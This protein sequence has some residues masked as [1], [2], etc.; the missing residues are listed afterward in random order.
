VNDSNRGL[1]SAQRRVLWIVLVAALI[2]FLAWLIPK[3]LVKDP[4]QVLEEQ[5]RVQKGALIL[6]LPPRPA[7]YP[8][9]VLLPR[10]QNAPVVFVESDDTALKRG[11]KYKLGSS[12]KSEGQAT[13][14][15]ESDVLDEV[16]EG[17]EH[18][19]LEIEI[20]RGQV[21]E[22]LVSDL[23]ARLKSSTIAADSNADVVVRSFEGPIRYRLARRSEY[24]LEL[25]KSF[26]DRLKS[27]DFADELVEV[28]VGAGS[29][30]ESEVTIQVSEPVVFAYVVSPASELSGVQSIDD[31]QLVPRSQMRSDTQA[32][33]VGLL[34]IG[35]SKLPD[36]TRSLRETGPGAEAA[37]RQVIRTAD[38]IRKIEGVHLYMKLP[39]PAA[40]LRP[41]RPGS[42]GSDLRAISAAAQRGGGDVAFLKQAL[43]SD[44][45]TSRLLAA[46][47]LGKLS[48]RAAPAAGSL[49]THLVDP[50]PAVRIAAAGA[51]LRVTPT[52]QVTSAELELASEHP[53]PAVRAK[54]AKTL[55]TQVPKAEATLLLER[56]ANDPDPTV[57]RAAEQ[58][59]RRRNI[60]IP[61]RAS[62]LERVAP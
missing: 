52:A 32:A 34:K 39:P 24:S 16:A 19:E 35:A 10:L 58:S 20:P 40:S 36:A 18:L 1:S 14:S 7:R 31:A 22:M 25:W 28:K 29:S 26:T 9:T 54:A 59:I 17:L 21:V 60:E 45:A 30:S 38:P 49:K 11:S 56:S 43:G 42:A 57:R 27:A 51:L 6:N 8:G 13:G 4:V 50:D 61:T 3:L 12:H 55:A 46:E 15:L 48:T 41:E 2:A 47:Y 53:D 23:L 37:L 44:D 33:V 62:S 5:L